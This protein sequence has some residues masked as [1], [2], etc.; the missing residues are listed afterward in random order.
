MMKYPA[1]TKTSVYILT[2]AQVY[3]DSADQSSLLRRSAVVKNSGVKS[4][5]VSGF[6]LS[7]GSFKVWE[8]SHHVSRSS[9]I[10]DEKENV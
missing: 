1:R 6:D 8:D 4:S 10:R 5:H 2:C 7:E 3:E 9:M